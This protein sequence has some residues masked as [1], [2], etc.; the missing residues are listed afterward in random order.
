AVR[1]KPW[2]LRVRDPDL[3]TFGHVGWFPFGEHKRLEGRGVG[4]DGAEAPDR[5]TQDR[6]IRPPE[7][8]VVPDPQAMVQ[9]CGPWEQDQTLPIDQEAHS[10]C[11]RMSR[12]RSPPP[13]LWV[14]RSTPVS[15]AWR[16]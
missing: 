8:Q 2:F 14:D 12:H 7:L 15:I 11:E 10:D 9:M 4:M 6:P 5:L 16:R 1:F 3:S 13:N